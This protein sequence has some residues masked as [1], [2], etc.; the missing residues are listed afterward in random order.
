GNL[1]PD[2]PVIIHGAG[3]SGLL[4]AYFLRQQGLAVT[5]YER[6]T[7]AGGKIRTQQTPHGPGESAANAIFADQD[8]LNLVAELDLSYIRAR[9][10]LKK[11]VYRR[12]RPRAFPLSV[13]ECLRLGL[14]LFRKT[15]Q[16]NLNQIS[17]QDY[18]SPLLG[19]RLT[20]QLL[21]AALAGIYAS[22]PRQ[23]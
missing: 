15:P 16:E 21:G 14:G 19:E 22:E 10:P 13:Y 4:L 1:E 8:V 2:K 11:K 6:D 17:I 23:L 7:R 18:F 20:E 3:I 5:V 12:G 9:S